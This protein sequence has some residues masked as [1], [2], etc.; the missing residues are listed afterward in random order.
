MCVERGE[1]GARC[2]WSEVCVEGGV[3]GVDFSD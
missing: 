2:A 1:R 3:R